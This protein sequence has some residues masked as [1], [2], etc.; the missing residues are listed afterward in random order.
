MSKLKKNMIANFFG[1]S[2]GA[3][4]GLIFTPIYI[5]L[6]GMESY[7]LIG[8]YGTLFSVFSLLQL[9]LSRT[10]NRELASLSVRENTAQQQRDLLRTL[11]IFYWGAGLLVCGVVLAL[12]PLIARHWVNPEQLS[13]ETVTTAIRVMAM[14]MILEFPFSLYQGGLMGLQRQVLLNGVMVCTGTLRSVGMLGVLWLISPTV[15]AFFFWQ[16]IV[17]FVRTVLFRILLDR[18][19][20]RTGQRSRFR[21]SA[22]LSVWRFAAGMAS[23]TLVTF[24]LTNLDKILLSKLLTLKMLG[25]YMLAFYLAN[26]LHMINIPIHSA[27]FPRLT[28]IVASGDER[29]VSHLYHRICQMISVLILPT[30]LTIAFFSRQI[31]Y[32]WTRDPEIADNVHQILTLLV[33]GTGVNSLMGIPYTLQIASGWTSLTFYVNLFSTIVL[34]PALFFFVPKYG[35]IGA[36]A[37]WL[38]L[39]ISFLV[40][41]LQIMHRQLLKGEQWRWYGVDIGLPFTGAATVLFCAHHFIP[42]EMSH[43]V[44]FFYIAGAWFLAFILSVSLAPLIRT[45]LLKLITQMKLKIGGYSL[46]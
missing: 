39:N 28:Q 23:I 33:L 46:L 2:W 21:K 36:A 7:G 16:L 27:V 38:T 1:R 24:C 19:I 3:M 14:V 22:L 9:G 41:P 45:E 10:L 4:L 17:S 32:I 15:K 40:V 44:M 6:I 34:A 26:S 11:E 5:R 8:F 31:L 30:A 20:P 43:I 37:V 29:A 12:A 18:S 42:S 25:F 35:G 13:V